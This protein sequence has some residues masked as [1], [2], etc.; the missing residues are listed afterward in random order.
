MASLTE[1][2]FMIYKSC[3]LYLL[4]PAARSRAP[5]AAAAPQI[6]LVATLTAAH[7][8]AVPIVSCYPA[9]GTGYLVPALRLSCIT[10]ARGRSITSNRRHAHVRKA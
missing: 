7:P 5:A 4:R 9:P 6:V 8:A 1:H 3:L 2:L 10:P